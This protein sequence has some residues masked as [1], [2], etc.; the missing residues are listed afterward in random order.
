V[1]EALDSESMEVSHASP[2]LACVWAKAEENARKV[3]LIVASGNSF[4]NQVIDKPEAE[5]ACTLVRTLLRNFCVVIAPE[6]ADTREAS[7]KRKLLAII[8]SHGTNGCTRATLTRRS[9]WLNKR[10]RNDCLDDLIESGEVT[11]VSLQS[12]GPGRKSICYMTSENV[13]LL[14]NGSE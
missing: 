10:S 13:E 5:Y 11:V 6:I 14:N 8:R 4:D 9:Q 1:F 12:D 7:I 2:S 3:A